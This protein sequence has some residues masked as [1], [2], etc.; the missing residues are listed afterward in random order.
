MAWARFEP[1]ILVTRGQDA[2]LLTTEATA[3]H[4]SVVWKLDTVFHDYWLG[5]GVYYLAAE[6]HLP[7]PI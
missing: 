2:N 3:H 6:F 5:V 4:M 1:A 7:G